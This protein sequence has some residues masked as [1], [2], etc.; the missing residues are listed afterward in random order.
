MTTSINS[1]EFEKKNSKLRMKDNRY[2]NKNDNIHKNEVQDIK[3]NWTY[4]VHLV[5]EGKY[6]IGFG[7]PIEFPSQ[8]KKKII[9]IGP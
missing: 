6:N 8:R 1:E 7:I 2:K 5:F 3:R 9:Q 4:V